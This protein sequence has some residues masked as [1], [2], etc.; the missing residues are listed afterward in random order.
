MSDSDPIPTLPP[1]D[2]H[3]CD[4]ADGYHACF[5]PGF[6]RRLSV[7]REGRETV[8]YEQDPKHPFVLPAGEKEPWPSCGLKFWGGPDERNLRLELYD[9]KHEVERIEIVLRKSGAAARS[10]AEGD[11]DGQGEDGEGERVVVENA[12]ILCPPFCPKD[13]GP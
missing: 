5:Y 7:V 10:L 3:K 11:D 4:E 8:V 9:P 6:V 13:E 12:A 2:P 1:S